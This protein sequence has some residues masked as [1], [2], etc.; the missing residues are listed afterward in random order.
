MFLFL[1]GCTNANKNSMNYTPSKTDIVSRNNGDIVNE[2]RLK[3]FIENTETGQT[4]SIRV[5]GYTKEGDPILTDLTINGEQ[6]KVTRDNTRDE[7][8]D[9]EIKT[10]ECEKILVEEKKYSILGC[11]GYEIPYYLAEGN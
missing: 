11:D 7:Y 10:F 2:I 5:V 1:Y 3:E 6:L 8:G 9:G 4:D